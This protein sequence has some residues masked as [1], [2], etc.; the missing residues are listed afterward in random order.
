MSGL[1]S[2]Y[3]IDGAMEPKNLFVKTFGCQMNESDS[4]RIINIL[5]GSGYR[6]TDDESMADVIILNTCSIR[7]K[8][9]HKVYSALGRF[10]KL[11]N[12]NK[13]LILGVGGCVA[14]Q[15]GER[16]LKKV[17]YLDMVFGTHNIHRLPSI[18]K[19]VE[20]KSAKVCETSFLDT[21]E[22]ED[23]FQFEDLELYSDNVS[24]SLR[25]V[26]SFVNIMRGCDNFCTFC[27][28]PNVRGK[29]ISRKSGSIIEEVMSLRD[30]GVKEVTLLGQN[31]NSY[32]SHEDEVSF[33]V[34]LDMIAEING[35]DRI[36][37]VTSHPKD[38]SKELIYAFKKND[39]L[40]SH[41][42]LPVQSGSNSVLKIMGRQHTKESYLEKV[43]ELRFSRPG[44][45]LTTD[46]IVGFPG[47][48][49]KDFQST[50][51]ILKEVEF[52]SIF[53]FRYSPR[54]GTA[55]SNFDNQLPEKVKLMRL[56]ELQHLQKGISE[57]KN[58]TLLGKVKQVLIEG[59]SKKNSSEL[60]G[61]TS[62]N[63][64]VNF[65]GDVEAIGNVAPVMIERAFTNSFHGRIV[66]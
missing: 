60:T 53:S 64:V 59:V 20:T 46:I 27:V 63:K 57:K 16:L 55:A 26:K 44:I 4:D 19:D 23:A 40:C 13:Q 7:D 41:L 50:I 34:L 56:Q 1:G 47:E 17:P 43:Y 38:L 49:E 31:V 42:H 3:K 36:R 12:E 18:M 15:E 48:R 14:Q 2:L 58:K 32:G 25:K 24:P 51:D 21:L 66:Q 5:R 22:P 37:F 29:E 10:K 28:V 9:E 61:R 39:K 6:L 30:E 33:S 52:D 35:I 11:K 65:I 62:S 45:S 8:A 54:P